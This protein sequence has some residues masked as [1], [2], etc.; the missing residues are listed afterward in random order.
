MA[1]YGHP[2]CRGN[3]RLSPCREKCMGCM[4][5]AVVRPCGRGGR[6]RNVGGRRHGRGAAL[7][8]HVPG[9]HIRQRPRMRTAS[10]PFDGWLRWPGATLRWN[11]GTTAWRSPRRPTRWQ[12]RRRVTW[13]RRRRRLETEARAVFIYYL[14]LEACFD[15]FRGHDHVLYTV[16]GLIHCDVPDPHMIRRRHECG[17]RRYP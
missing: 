15:V 6:F 9:P 8:D 1:V 10:L 5:H 12:R 7:R 16:L 13:R 17:P 3:L 11:L 4:Q 14:G 2:F